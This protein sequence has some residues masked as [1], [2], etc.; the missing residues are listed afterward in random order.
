MFGVGYEELHEWA[1]RGDRAITHM[2]EWVSDESRTIA[3]IFGIVL[4]V[5]VIVGAK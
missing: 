3:L 5:W 2:W 4:V 1:E